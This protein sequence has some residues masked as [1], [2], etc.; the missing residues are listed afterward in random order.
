MT[1]KKEK[2]LHSLVAGSTAGAIEACVFG[3][4]CFVT[5]ST[6]IVKTRSQFGGQ[7]RSSPS[8]CTLALTVPPLTIIR[9]T[10]RERDIIGLYWEM[11]SR[12]G[13]TSQ[14]RS[15]SFSSIYPPDT[16]Q[17]KVSTPKSLVGANS[18]VRFTTHSTL[19]QFAQSTARPG[20]QLPSG[21]TFAI[22]AIAGLVTCH[23]EAH[24]V[25]QCFSRVRKLVPLWLPDFDRGRLVTILDWH[26]I[27]T[28]ATSYE[29][30]NRLYGIRKHY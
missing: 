25:S 5:F 10:L 28:N 30:W 22:S 4:V 7:V 1:S 23:E 16:P 24:A 15:L 27:K 13:S 26:D 19:K 6:E 29:W 17:G 11:P 3:L 21:I 9:T 14:Y 20:Q 2:P 18:A 12:P 8:V